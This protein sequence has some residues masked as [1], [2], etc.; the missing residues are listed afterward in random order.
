MLLTNLT[1]DHA[2]VLIPSLALVGFV[3]ANL[4]C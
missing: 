4:G 3:F 1:V 2:L